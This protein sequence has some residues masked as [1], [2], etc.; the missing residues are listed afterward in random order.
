MQIVNYLRATLCNSSNAAFKLALHAP[1]YA[2]LAHRIISFKNIHASFTLQVNN[3][4]MNNTCHSADKTSYSKKIDES[5]QKINKY[6]VFLDKLDFIMPNSDYYYSIGPS[7]SANNAC[8][9]ETQR[10]K[11]DFAVPEK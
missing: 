5:F 3:Y 10:E 4:K 1:K 11:R 8:V 2:T 9:N 7:F 6:N